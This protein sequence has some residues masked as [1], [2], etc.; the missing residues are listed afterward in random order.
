MVDVET[1]KRH[2]RQEAGER[3]IG[4]A[5]VSAEGSPSEIGSNGESIRLAVADEL[6]S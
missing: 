6:E 5:R 1:E 3:M 4:L 2:S